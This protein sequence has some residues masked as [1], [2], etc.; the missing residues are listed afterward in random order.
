MRSNEYHQR[1]EDLIKENPELEALKD[2]KR[3]EIPE[4]EMEDNIDELVRIMHDRFM[5][6]K[7]NYDYASIDNN[8]TLDDLQ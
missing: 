2:D 6:G 5:T 4:D 7:D 3:E 1:V 8:T